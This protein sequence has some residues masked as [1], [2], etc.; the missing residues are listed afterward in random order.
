MSGEEAAEDLLFDGLK[1]NR[2]GLLRLD[3]TGRAVPVALG[4]RALDLLLLLAKHEGAVV[5]KG[6]IMA[7]VWP[8]IAVEESNL[9]KQISALRRALDQSREN[10]SC[11]QTVPGRGYR[12]VATV[13]RT[14]QPTDVV[15]LPAVREEPS[16]AVLPFQN[17]NGAPE[18]RLFCR[19]HGRRHHD[20]DRTLSLALR[21]RPRFLL[22]L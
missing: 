17:L 8:G 21:R 15:P 1:L 16:I 11:I 19:R 13:T 3:P 18:F 9:T 5:S 7:G 2:R 14:D 4:S 22:C 12:F 20:R 10:G 6:D